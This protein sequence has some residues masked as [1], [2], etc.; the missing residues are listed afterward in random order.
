MALDIGVGDGSSMTPDLGE[1]SLSLNDDGYYWFLHPLWERLQSET[2]QYIDM[3]GEAS[4]ADEEL[5]ALG[6]VL[7]EARRLVEAQPRAWS[8][9]VGFQ[10]SPEH[11]ESYCQVQ[12]DAMLALLDRWSAVVA[13]ARHL[14]RPVVCLGD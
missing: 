2:G 8:V 4:F 3:Y 9:H 1:P 7:A 11:R 13:R 5:A 10:P 12:R 6:R 14:G